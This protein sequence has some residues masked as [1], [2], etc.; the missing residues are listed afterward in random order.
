MSEDD[1]VRCAMCGDAHA[2]DAC[3]ALRA[4]SAA[5]ARP[6][7]VSLRV[8]G[9]YVE[10]RSALRANAHAA[11]CRVLEWLLSHVAEER[12][13]PAE[14]GFA[15]KLE[16]LCDDGVISARMQAALF[17][18]AVAH[19]ESPEQAWALMSMAEHAF[20]RLYVSKSAR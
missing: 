8:Y 12:G 18:Q 1:A 5:G 10:A 16:R 20:A 17:E 2:A 3:A 13:A 7:G 4:A 14:L 6:Q 11:A 15:A 9:G 19:D